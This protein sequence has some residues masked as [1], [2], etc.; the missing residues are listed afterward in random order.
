MCCILATGEAISHG[1]IPDVY[2]ETSR[3]LCH[4]RRLRIHPEALSSAEL[5]F[6]VN[7]PKKFFVACTGAS[8]ASSWPVELY[9]SLRCLQFS[10][11]CPTHAPVTSTS[12]RCS[13]PPSVWYAS[14]QFLL[15]LAAS[16]TARCS[17]Q[18]TPSTKMS[19]W[20]PLGQHFASPTEPT[21]RA[22][23][24]EEQT[25]ATGAPCS[26]RWAPRSEVTFSRRARSTTSSWEKSLIT[27]ELRSLWSKLNTWVNKVNK[28][29]W[30]KLPNG[31]LDWSSARKTARKRKDRL[32]RF[33][34]VDE[35]ENRAGN[36]QKYPIEFSFYARFYV[37]VAIG[38]QPTTLLDIKCVRSAADRAGKWTLTRQPTIRRTSSTGLPPTRKNL[39]GSFKVSSHGSVSPL[40]SFHTFCGSRAA[41]T[42]ASTWDKSRIFLRKRINVHGPTQNLEIYRRQQFGKYNPINTPQSCD[43]ARKRRN[44]SSEF[45]YH[46]SPA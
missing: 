42:V 39:W 3:L 31:G 28:F 27:F 2:C 35:H 13:A 5:V 4:L 1:R 43:W 11:S 34:A 25:R 19:W 38:E 41:S 33:A 20:P 44:S 17:R 10:T 8:I 18:S 21:W 36:R 12:G 24:L 9:D 14:L 15:A 30:S 46:T 6:A 26:Y 7:H 45:R 16:Q 22:F 37:M 23:P 40:Q 32:L 29:F